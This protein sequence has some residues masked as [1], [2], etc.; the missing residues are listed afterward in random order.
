MLLLA[1]QFA[2]IV[3]ADGSQWNQRCRVALW[4]QQL[5]L[6]IHA[7][8]VD[9]KVNIMAFGNTEWKIADC[10]YWMCGRVLCYTKKA[11]FGFSGK[12][13]LYSPRR[14]LVK[15]IQILGLRFHNS[16]L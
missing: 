15:I 3:S 9:F 16:A 5:F 10:F 12:Y 6:A 11:K 1:T 7:Q 4:Q 2:I 14:I 13:S 8:V